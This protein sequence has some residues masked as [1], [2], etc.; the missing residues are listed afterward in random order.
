MTTAALSYAID[1][2][3][4]LIRVDEGYYRFAEENGWADAGSSLGRLLWDY[5]AGRELV[6]LQRMLIRRVRDEVGNVELPF[7]CDGPDVRREM[8]VRIVARPGGRVVL[9]SSQLRTEEKRDLPQRLLDPAMPRSDEMLEMCGWCDR[10]EVDEEWVEVEE[11]ARRL[12]LFNRSELPA[13]SHGVCPECNEM[14]LA[15]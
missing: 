15:A 11:A 1:E 7:R 12:E 14:L 2:H 4:H 8:D 10:F 9:F 5:V 13:L 3:D 6:K